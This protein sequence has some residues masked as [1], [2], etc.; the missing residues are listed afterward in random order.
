MLYHELGDD[1][2]HLSSCRETGVRH[3]AHESHVASSVDDAYTLLGT[4]EAK[5][6]GAFLED[7]RHMVTRSTE[8]TYIVSC[9]GREEIRNGKLF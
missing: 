4:E 2:C 5:L 3:G 1:T 8:D 6:T 7:G 9:H